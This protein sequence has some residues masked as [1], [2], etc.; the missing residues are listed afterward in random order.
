MDAST[1]RL[2]LVGIGIVIIVSI[3]YISGSSKRRQKNT[4]LKLDK[5][6]RNT[7]TEVKAEASQLEPGVQQELDALKGMGEMIAADKREVVASDEQEFNRHKSPLVENR[8][9]SRK[10]VTLY[11][12]SIGKQRVQGTELRDALI[13]TGLVYGSQQ[14]FHRLPEGSS[15]AIFSLA[16]GI[17]PGTF[18]PATWNLFETPILTLFYSLPGQ[19]GAL[20]AW[21]AMLP[22]ANRL[23]ELLGMA[24]LDAK[25]MPLTRERIAEIR[26]ELRIF[27]RGTPE[28]G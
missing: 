28:S 21:D 13:K 19:Y 26:E 6:Q 9:L 23:S 12:Q 16:N 25:Q 14:W 5:Q 18:D 24:V 15:E 10:V 8:N 2:A 20:D 22:T 7:P 1:L 3:F 17:K 4:K 27:D 11:L